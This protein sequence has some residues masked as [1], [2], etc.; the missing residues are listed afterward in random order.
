MAKDI[1]YGADARLRLR[2]GIDKLANAVKSTLGPKGKNVIIDNGHFDPIVTKDGVT[3]AKHVDL[4]DRYE[5]AGARLVR[6]V[7]S[8]TN[9]EVGDGTTTST[10][11]AQELIR[12]GFK[13]IED[14]PFPLDVHALRQGMSEAVE[15]VVRSLNAQKVDLG[16]DGEL[17]RRVATISANNDPETGNLIADLMG[18]VGKDGVVTTEESQGL[19]IETSFVEGVQIDRGWVSPYM[20]TNADRMQAVHENVKILITDQRLT[21][22]QDVISI[23]EK[24][25]QAGTKKLVIVADDISGD[26]LATIVVNRMKGQFDCVAV[27]APGFGDVRSNM[28]RDL[29]ILTGGVFLTEAIGRK[30]E[31]LSPDELGEAKKVIVEKDKTT[32]IGGRADQHEVGE[33]V[34]EVRTLLEKVTS[35]YDREKLHDRLAMLQGK[36]ALIK[37]GAATQAEMEERKFLIEDAISATKAALENGIVPGGGTALL[38]SGA[39]LDAV[40]F[41]D[42]GG[43]ASESRAIGRRIV[44]DA[45]AT[46]FSTIVRNAGKDAS[47]LLRDLEAR[48]RAGSRKAGY[49][50]KA[51]EFCDDMVASGIVDP[52]KVTVATIVNALSAAS[53]ILTTECLMS[54]EPEEKPKR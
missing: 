47:A 49:D 36:V 1:F 43:A 23:Y 34:A 48:L 29:A 45:L 41:T 7:A 27:R 21:S 8:K 24:M 33:R 40:A 37:V 20:V 30:L 44:R 31:S 28:L 12:L 38:V 15:E 42:A 14:S 46:P 3:V 19:G 11:L 10:L 52:L 5:K 53:L 54:E 39:D 22:G 25:A 13:A 6:N 51:E 16:G 17:L 2:A 35:E 26:A 18:K 50:A 9:D 32:F 4:K